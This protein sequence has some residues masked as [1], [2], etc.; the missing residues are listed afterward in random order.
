MTVART[1]NEVPKGKGNVAKKMLKFGIAGDDVENAR[2]AMLEAK[3]P[4]VSKISGQ[5]IQPKFMGK[6]PAKTARQ[7]QVP[8]Q[9]A[10]PDLSD[11]IEEGSP[12]VAAQPVA[13]APAKPVAQQARVALDSWD[14]FYA[15]RGL[16]QADVAKLERQGSRDH[17]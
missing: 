17:S 13:Q 15:T 16:A 6:G 7:A 11:F 1:P 2:Q 14:T 12:V 10:Q 8:A 5:V 4:F 3:E 9:P